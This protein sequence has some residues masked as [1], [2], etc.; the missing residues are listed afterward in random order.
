MVISHTNAFLCMKLFYFSL[1][2][3][4]IRLSNGHRY[5]FI[6]IKGGFLKVVLQLKLR[7]DHHLDLTKAIYDPV[8]RTTYTY[9]F[10]WLWQVQVFPSCSTHKHGLV[11][12]D[13]CDIINFLSSLIALMVNRG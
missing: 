6:N 13:N 9:L 10:N 1:I 5:T 3:I 2:P 4:L 8:E 7:L 11:G 12:T